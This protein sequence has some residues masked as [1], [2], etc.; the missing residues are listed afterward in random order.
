MSNKHEGRAHVR[1]S[2][3]PSL[4][5]RAPS[6]IKQVQGWRRPIE[7]TRELLNRLKFLAEQLLAGFK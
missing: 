7:P 3:A 2:F 5:K 4:T 6:R 1:D